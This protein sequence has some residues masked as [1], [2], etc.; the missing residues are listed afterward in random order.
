[1]SRLKRVPGGDP[2]RGTQPRLAPQT[3]RQVINELAN[4]SGYVLVAIL[5][6]PVLVIGVVAY[7]LGVDALAVFLAKALMR[8]VE[9][10]I[11]R[12]I[13]GV[14]IISLAGWGTLRVY[15]RRRLR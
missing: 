7:F 12:V 11:V 3:R 10:P 6:L 1:V 4:G 9:A 14:T 8:A 13:F 15:R 2:P 5:A